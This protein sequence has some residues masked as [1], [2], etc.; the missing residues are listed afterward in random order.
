MFDLQN[1]AAT[2][3]DVSLR[4]SISV[5]FFN[6]ACGYFMNT[7]FP[8]VCWDVFKLQKSFLRLPS[9]VCFLYS[10]YLLGGGVRLRLQ[11]RGISVGDLYWLIFWSH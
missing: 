2:F 1:E 8:L 7:V 10:S 3:P 6:S 4:F 5:L 9:T 11:R